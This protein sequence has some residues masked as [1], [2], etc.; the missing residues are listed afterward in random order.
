LGPGAGVGVGIGVGIVVGMVL[1][2]VDELDTFH[3]CQVP[4]KLT[5]PSPRARF[6]DLS[7]K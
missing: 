3:T 2:L 4:P 7:W 5:M 1:V 6:F